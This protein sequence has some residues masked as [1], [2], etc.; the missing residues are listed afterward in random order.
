M[1]SFLESFMLRSDRASEK[2]HREATRFHCQTLQPHFY[3]RL[4]SRGRCVCAP[5]SERLEIGIGMKHNVQG[6]R[7]SAQRIDGLY[8]HLGYEQ[9]VIFCCTLTFSWTR[10]SHSPQCIVSCANT[11]WRT[12]WSYDSRIFR[13]RE[14]IHNNVLITH[15]PIPQL[16]L[17]PKQI[18]PD[19]NITILCTSLLPEL[20]PPMAQKI[21]HPLD[22]VPQREELFSRGV[23]ITILAIRPL[24]REQTSMPF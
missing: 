17:L 6:Q 2:V 19:M 9:F 7:I 15:L 21:V 16:A 4:H 22:K 24:I 3:G 13:T 10:Q 23:D 8:L 20:V 11:S 5:K 14:I 18:E 1:V 12:P